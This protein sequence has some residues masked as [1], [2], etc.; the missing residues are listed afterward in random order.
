M[1]KCALSMHVLHISYPPSLQQAADCGAYHC[2]ATEIVYL[3]IQIT[4]LKAGTY[5]YWSTRTSSIWHNNIHT[6]TISRSSW[7][8]CISN[9]QL[10]HTASKPVTARFLK[11]GEGSVIKVELKRWRNSTS[12]PFTLP[13]TPITPSLSPF[14]FPSLPHPP[15][16]WSR[17][18]KYI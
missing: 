1:E 17:P 18:F 4:A 10:R 2:A 11:M 8:T 12:L 6:M 14:P 9:L 16:L 3:L 13:C 7:Y 15:L 5:L